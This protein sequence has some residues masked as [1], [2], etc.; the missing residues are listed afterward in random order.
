MTSLE[1]L[2]RLV[3]WPSE[4]DANTVISDDDGAVDKLVESLGPSHPTHFLLIK[5]VL[6]LANLI[7]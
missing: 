2:F 1:G 6:D 7:I 5:N 3:T 4:K